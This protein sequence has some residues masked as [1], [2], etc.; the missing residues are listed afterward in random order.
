MTI[1][2]LLLPLLL[3]LCCAGITYADSDRAPEF[4]DAVLEARIHQLHDI[5]MKAKLTPSVK[6]YIRT[7][8]VLKREHASFILGR[9]MMYFPLFEETMRKHNLPEGLKYL[10]ITESAL[11]PHA[12][13]RSGA[14]GLWQFMPVT[15]REYGLYNRGDIDERSHPA[16]STDAAA[17]YLKNLY[18]RYGKWE[19]A[20][21]AYNSGPGRVNRA[22]RRGRSKNFWR[23]KRY[24]PRETRAYVPGYIGAAYLVHFYKDHGIQPDEPEYDLQVTETTTV[25][26]RM[27]FEEIADITGTPMHIIVELNPHFV[28]RV[29]PASAEGHQV[30]LPYHRIGT[31][32]RRLYNITDVPLEAIVK[33][34][35]KERDVRR[36]TYIVAEGEDIYSIAKALECKPVNIRTWN[37]LQAGAP[38][39][40]GQVLDIMVLKPEPDTADLPLLSQDAVGGISSAKVAR[41]LVPTG[42]LPRRFN[43]HRTKRRETLTDVAR[44]Y[45]VSVEDLL[46]YNDLPSRGRLGKGTLVSV[47]MY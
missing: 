47:P 4:S 32:V 39:Q 35:E 11:K 17:R 6:S 24:L 7:Y 13:S 33:A 42:R 31:L 41:Q 12:L 10:A 36:M 21:A 20:L 25:Y 16:K 5:P 46:E 18:R 15:G 26:K 23:I 29:V 40:V 8:T 19:L 22:I 1:T 44:E 34:T 43:V 45:G 27:T 9:T 3:A 30:T 38:L 37:K 14:V 2:K 28:N